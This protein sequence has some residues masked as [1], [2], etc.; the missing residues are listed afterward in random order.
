MN[1]AVFN[2]KQANKQKRKKKNKPKKKEK[3][4]KSR[5]KRLTYRGGHSAVP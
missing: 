5:D 1:F 3:E 4:K 2:V